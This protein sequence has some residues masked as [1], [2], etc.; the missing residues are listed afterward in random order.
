V[1][2]KNLTEF[3]NSN[4]LFVPQLVYD[5]ISEY[6]FLLYPE[7]VV[8]FKVEENSISSNLTEVTSNQS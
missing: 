1:T 6:G 7:A 2:E 4:E 5:S 8:K 3:A